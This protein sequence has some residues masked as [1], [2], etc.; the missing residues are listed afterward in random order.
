MPDRLVGLMGI[1][2]YDQEKITALY[3][4]LLADLIPLAENLCVIGTT[5][6]RFLLLQDARSELNK[7]TAIIGAKFFLDVRAL[8]HTLRHGF[9][10]SATIPMR[11]LINQYNLLVYLHAY[12]DE[13]GKWREAETT[14]QRR[15]FDLAVIRKKVRLGQVWYEF[16]DL[17]S[18]YGHMNDFTSA[19]FGRQ[20]RYF[21]YDLVASGFWDPRQLLKH[22]NFVLDIAYFFQ[23]ELNQRYE[24][25][26]DPAHILRLER[27]R[28]DIGTASKLAESR[29][30]SFVNRFQVAYALDPYLQQV[31]QGKAVGL[32]DESWPEESLGRRSSCP[33][34]SGK[35]FKNC[36]G[37]FIEAGYEAW[38]A[39]QGDS[40]RPTRALTKSR[41]KKVKMLTEILANS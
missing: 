38:R 31:A 10:S 4:E 17:F 9:F 32:L 36:H 6:L 2:E 40:P 28:T 26:V 19:T 39:S 5:G 7:A 33:C 25:L 16:Y 41:K 37:A 15:K 27:L 12:P 21:G 29:A 3:E 13:A 20:R 34:G 22:W 18:K 23:C 8:T 14:S 24:S 11:E 30:H 35:R 1:A